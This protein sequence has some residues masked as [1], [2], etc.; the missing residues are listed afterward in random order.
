M[1]TLCSKVTDIKQFS[2]K[3]ETP[4]RPGLSALDECRELSVVRLGEELDACLKLAAEKLLTLADKAPGLDMYHLH[5]DALD[6][7][8][9][10]RDEIGKGFR[11]AFLELFNQRCRRDRRSE[12]ADDI[13][14][15]LVEPDD[16]EQ[17]LAAQA[18]ATSI[19]NASGEELFGLG[20][21]IGLLLDDPE[22]CQADNPLGP[23]AIGQA[24]VAALD[25]LERQT[26]AIKVRLLVVSLLNRSL[27][28][29]IKGVYQA[30]NRQLLKRGVLPALRVGM[31]RPRHDSGRDAAASAD[32][33]A[34]ETDLF[35]T[36]RQLMGV[37]RPAGNAPAMSGMPSMQ[38]MPGMA[39]PE[40]PGALVGQYPAGQV[41]SGM[42]VFD[43]LNRLQHGQVAGE[44]G[45]DPSV[46]GSGRIN[47]LHDIQRSQLGHQLGPL[48]VMTL[49]IVA[50][51]FDF[52]L[53]DQRIPDAMKALIGR[54]Q[55]PVLKVAM[56][57][58]DFFS[59]KTHPARLLLDA[60]AE[61]AFGWDAA[62]GHEGGLYL[63]I[64]GLVQGILDGYDND[65]AIFTQ[66]LDE[67]RGFLSVEQDTAL[68]HVD[69]SAQVIHS[70]EQEDL[71]LQVAHAEI[72]SRLLGT[73]TPETTRHFV[74][75]RW[76]PWLAELYLD[77]G[78]DSPAWLEALSTLDDLIWSVQPKLNAAERKRFLET[79]PGL[80]KRLDADLIAIGLPDGQRDHFFADLVT[81]HADAVKAEAHAQELAAA[82]AETSAAEAIDL[83]ISPVDTSTGE[84]Q[85][86]PEASQP[87]PDY[88]VLV[89]TLNDPASPDQITGLAGL[90]RGTWIEYRQDDGSPL[91]A[92][93]FWISPLKGLYLF[94]NRLGQRAISITAEGLE[95]KLRSGE[96][97]IVDGAPLIERAVS[98]MVAKLQQRVA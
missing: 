15:A 57:D 39:W 66:A 92:R 98:H 85:P 53:D 12:T 91:R 30:I 25:D 7:V 54:L 81:C 41:M 47:F 51:L 89:T 58:K 65:A 36:L 71:A 43:T 32:P 6:L 62:E 26:V 97:S 18:L 16:L 21:R 17:R 28:E 45:L 42:P 69:R 64:D 20:Q 22:L 34:P 27:P 74:Q 33:A 37:G 50:L 11:K 46:L 94:S 31:Q 96:V 80:L 10:H 83:P 5:L 60:L 75:T 76:E 77:P 2:Q 72:E 73:Q 70:Q 78:E 3:R 13:Q 29:R 23:E 88:P 63:K 8:R 61:A 95:R 68:R 87:L 59:H 55:I 4:K 79:L 48:D 84:F 14:F 19:S 35:A 49:D 67:L 82:E 40:M 24:L 44:V 1:V 86:V 90:K 56:L 38:G 52:I 93:L 9:E